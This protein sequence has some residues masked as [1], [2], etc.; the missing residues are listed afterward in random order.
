M[1]LAVYPSLKKSVFDLHKAASRWKGIVQEPDAPTYAGRS[2]F[3]ELAELERVQA[4]RM[5]DGEDLS[6]KHHSQSLQCY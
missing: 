4:R 6:A 5:A 1:M 2:L 3:L